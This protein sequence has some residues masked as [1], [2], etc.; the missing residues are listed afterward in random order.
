M[1]SH[2]CFRKLL[3]IPYS[4]TTN[5]QIISPFPVLSTSVFSLNLYFP[6][7]FLTYHRILKGRD[8]HPRKIT[9]NSYSVKRKLPFLLCLVLRVWLYPPVST[10]TLRASAKTLEVFSQHDT[11]VSEKGE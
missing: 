10:S 5:K 3:A 6:L 11:P 9:V 4:L 2:F 7:F 1:D 8:E